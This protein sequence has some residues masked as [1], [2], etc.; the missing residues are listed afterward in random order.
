MNEERFTDLAGAYGGDVSRWPMQ[1]W[2]A[3]AAFMAS[4]PG[5]SGRILAEAAEL[6]VALDAW[7]SIPADAALIDRILASA[8]APRAR[9]SW[10]EW[11]APVGLGAGLATACAVGLIFGVQITKTAIEQR[12]AVILALDP[13]LVGGDV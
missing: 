8:P 11:L 12:E 4:A 9:R 1:T 3:A 13:T 6:D 5:L 7:G 10:R 2:D